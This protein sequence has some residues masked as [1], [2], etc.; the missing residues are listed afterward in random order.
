VPQEIT[1]LSNRIRKGRRDLHHARAESEKAIEDAKATAQKA[2]DDLN[3]RLDDMQGPRPQ[4]GHA[5]P[6]HPAARILLNYCV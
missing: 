5:G 6:V 2:I 1:G 4:V 3:A